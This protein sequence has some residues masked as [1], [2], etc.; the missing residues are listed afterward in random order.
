[1]APFIGATDGGAETMSTNGTHIN[2]AAP[3][4]PRRKLRIAWVSSI[5]EHK[6]QH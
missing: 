6:Q 1:M 5:V 2:G 3:A 4:L